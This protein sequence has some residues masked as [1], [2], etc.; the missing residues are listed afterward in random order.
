[1]NR[2]ARETAIAFGD[3]GDRDYE[4]AFGATAAPKLSVPKVVAKATV[5]PTPKP[6]SSA[7]YPD[8]SHANFLE[9][10]LGPIQSAPVLAPKMTPAMQAAADANAK[11]AEAARA[12]RVEEQRQVNQASYNTY[13]ASEDKK[14][15][16]VH[17]FL[18]A[19]S[20]TYRAN[21]KSIHE[22]RTDWGLIPAGAAVLATG[23]AIIATGGAVAGAIAAPSLATAAGAA[24]AADR[25]LAAA[26]KAKLV[27]PGAT[28][29]VGQVLSAAATAQNVIDTTK[30]LA[31]AGVPGAI[32]GVKVIAK[33][34]AERAISGALP[35]VPQALTPQG[36]VAFDNYVGNAPPALQAALATIT[37]AAA[38]PAAAALAKQ[39]RVAVTMT[40]KAAPVV[41][42]AP[43]TV[44]WFVSSVGKVT[45]GSGSGA[46][47]R[48]YSDGK[49]VKQ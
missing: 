2:R 14:A 5:V 34:A 48:V 1:M 11:A 46:G 12:K 27:K 13:R 44:A 4:A 42:L 39:K 30:A 19:T 16:D 21:E 18:M 17:D 8:V 7:P 40:K 23:A 45:Q 10:E 25:A 26:E 15:Q 29:A 37:P 41:Q 20:P 6:T 24:V 49:V 9:P 36:A 47:W 43:P 31:D 33:T 35:G 22:A 38:Y 32:E 28:G 3:R